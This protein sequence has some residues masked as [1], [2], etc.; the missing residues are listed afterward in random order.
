MSI[1]RKGFTLI[2]LLV[3][4][5][6][7][8][9]LIGMLLP[10]V[11]TARE[12]ARRSDCANR[13][14]QCV[15][16][17]HEFHE[18]NQSLPVP[19]LQDQCTTNTTNH[20]F[21]HQCTSTLGLCMP[22]L[23]L[24][25]MYDR[26][27]ADAFST[28]RD[29]TEIVDSAGVRIY[30]NAFDVHFVGSTSNTGGSDVL[31]DYFLTRVPDFEC[32]SDNIN[33]T[34]FPMTPGFLPVGANGSWF[35]YTPSWNGTTNTDENWSGW[36]V[37]YTNGG[38]PTTDF[39]AHRSNYLGCIGAHGHT[40]DQQ[41]RKW[42][43]TLV[44]RDRITLETIQDGSSRTVLMGEFIGPIF[45]F[46]RGV[47]I[48]DDNRNVVTPIVGPHAWIM[49][50]GVQMRGHIPYLTASFYDFDP[51]Y[52]IGD[53]N[54]PN[55]EVFD[56]RGIPMLGDSQFSSDRGFGSNHGAGVNFGLG[57]GHVKL[58]NRSVDWMTLYQIGGARDGQVPTEF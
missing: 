3:V 42:I 50:G 7:I 2:E 53:P 46:V 49:N 47:T 11:Q 22:Y 44:P 30:A 37:Y 27:N 23:E 36:A 18:A 1:R 35:A 17:V 33:D 19:L 57:D 52:K 54:D 12:V 56:G 9:I 55:M 26:G 5:A 13:L 20:Y 32:P 16:A 8:G 6:I 24:K 34:I 38:V 39:F 29:L 31:N 10:A 51:T 48:D 28:R 45:N 58:V 21:N 41:R 25:N 40:V 4:M 15:L 14:R 43:G